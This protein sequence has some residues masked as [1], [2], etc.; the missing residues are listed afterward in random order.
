MHWRDLED[1]GAF[2]AYMES[3]DA[4]L[5]DQGVDIPARPLH[6]MG[7]VSGELKISFTMNS[8]VYKRVNGWFEALY[9]ERLNM[10]FSI[11]RMLVLIRGDPYFARFPVAFGR[12]KLN[13]LQ[14]IEGTTPAALTALP[15]LDLQAL[16]ELVKNGFDAFMALVHVPRPV[17][18]DANSAVAQVMSRSPSPGLSKW[19]SQQ[20]VEKML[21]GYV[22]RKGGDAKRARRGGTHPHDL[23]PRIAEALRCGLAAPD[24]ADVKRVECTAHV[25]YPDNDEGRAVT[26]AN[27]VEANQAAVF[28]CASIARQW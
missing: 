1:P 27:A 2:S 24:P 13:L 7:L 28:L 17:I 23:V 12:A 8:S 3:L 14:V 5:R 19:A 15:G 4:R 16:L 9:C 20:M 25:R 6:A 22:E 26:V 21:N 10:D 18:A 11:V